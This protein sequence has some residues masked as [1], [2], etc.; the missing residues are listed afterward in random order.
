MNKEQIY[1][2]HDGIEI[3]SI[4]KSSSGV[5]GNALKNHTY[6]VENFEG[7]F[8]EFNSSTEQ[9]IKDWKVFS[10]TCVTEVSEGWLPVEIDYE[11]Y[12]TSNIIGCDNKGCLFNKECLCTATNTICLGYVETRDKK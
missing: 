5:C 2:T 4:T 8:E 1:I 11:E 10:G 7:S 6:F 9:F 3:L 12:D